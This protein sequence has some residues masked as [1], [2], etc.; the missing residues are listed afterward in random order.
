MNEDWFSLRRTSYALRQEAPC[1]FVGGD[2]FLVKWGS[3]RIDSTE[4]NS[5]SSR[6]ED[7]TEIDPGV[8]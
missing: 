3:R 1:F 8:R 6:F 4:T 2:T 7:K 5:T